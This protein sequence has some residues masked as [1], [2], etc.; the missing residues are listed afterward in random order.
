M[1]GCGLL[2]AERADHVNGIGGEHENGEAA[3]EQ[4]K[5][6]YELAVSELSGYCFVRDRH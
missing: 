5:R 2:L 4:G 6:W 1:R 3:D